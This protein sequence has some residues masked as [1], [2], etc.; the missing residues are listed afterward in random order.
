[1]RSRTPKPFGA[2]VGFQASAQIIAAA[3]LQTA[4]ANLADTRLD[5][6]LGARA[7]ECGQ[8]EDADVALFDLQQ[9]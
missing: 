1:M 9:S 7:L 4:M 5:A 8:V 2:G 3:F 6:R